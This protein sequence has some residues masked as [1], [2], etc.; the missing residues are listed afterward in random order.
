MAKVLAT[1]QTTIIDYNDAI[2]LQSYISSNKT[3]TQMYNQDNDSYNPDWGASNLVL[4][5]S[6]FILGTPNDIIGTAAVTSVEWYDVSA[7]VE[8]KIV[9]GTDYTALTT[10]PYTLTVKK[11]V[12]AG[13]PGKDYMCKI[14]YH[15][16]STGLNLTVK[17]DITFSRVVNGSG[18]ADAIAWLPEG[19]VFKNGEVDFLTAQCDMWRGSTIDTTNVTYQWYQ[20]DPS[21]ITDVGGGAGWKKLANIANS[22]T[23]VT[24]NILKIFPDAVINYE[25]FKCI[26]KDTDSTSTSYNQNFIDTVTVADQSDPI[27][28]TVTSSGGNIFKNSDGVSTL[29]AK[30][31]QAGAEIDVAGTKY[32]YKWYKY[33]NDGKLVADWSRTT[34]SI[35]VGGADVDTKATFN[36]EVEG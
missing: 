31:Y 22:T 5:P 19:N 4:T 25:V 34:K 24:T 33:G 14:V 26:I 11:N 35:T 8:T 20:Q 9:D 7:G 2:S 1:G 30:L 36:V 32:T 17:T 28:C 27:Q 16:D 10:K 12:L 3:K 6:L 13:I 18:I 23:G 29:T 21:Q 15:D